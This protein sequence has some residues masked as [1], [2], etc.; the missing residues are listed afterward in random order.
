MTKTKKKPDLSKRV[1][2]QIHEKQLKIRPRIYFVAGSLLLGFGLAGTIA[3]AVF[4][5]N[6]FLFRVRT[7]G[8]FDYLWFGRFGLR[9]FLSIF[10]WIPFLIA[11]AGIFGGLILLKRYDISYKKNFWGLVI[12]LVTFILVVGFFLDRVGFNEKLEGLR[13]VHPL[14]QNQFMG[15]DWIIGEIIQVE[16]RELIVVSPRGEKIRVVI[17]KNSLLPFGGDFKP[18][19]RIRA[20]GEWSPPSRPEDK[21]FIAKGISKADLPWQMFKGEVKGIRDRR[22]PKP[23]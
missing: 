2:K 18:G 20:V 3:V 10:P 6:L 15:R 21:V 12:S 7:H 8:P 19:E 13:P 11:I 16:D 14:Y 5:I 22:L 17:N 4:F 1:M 23:W 9:P